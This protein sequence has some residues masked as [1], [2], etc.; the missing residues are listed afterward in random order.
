MAERFRTG[1]IDRSGDQAPTLDFICRVC[2]DLLPI[3]VASVVLTGDHGV[4]GSPGYPIHSQPPYGTR[5]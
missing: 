5:N 4:E 2:C 1:V 3:T